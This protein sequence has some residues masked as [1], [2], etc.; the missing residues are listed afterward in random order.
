MRRLLLCVLI[1][2]AAL[3]GA[4]GCGGDDNSASPATTTEGST[5]AATTGETSDE[6]IV[7]G[8]AVS[9]T[10]F[11]TQI[12][13][14][15]LNGAKLAIE[16]VNERG[17]VLGRPLELITADTK[18]DVATV[19]VAAL[20]VIENGADIVL[21]TCDYDFGGPA[22]RVANEK[23]LL[24]IGCSGSHLY[25]VKGIGPLAFNTHSANATEAAT[26]AEFAYK[27]G[28]RKPYYLIDPSLEYTK[29]LC[30]D[31]E[32]V[33]DDFAGAKSAVGTD[34]FQPS[35]PSIAPQITRFKS[36]G[37]DADVI[38]LCSVQPAEGSAIRQIRAAGIDTPIVSG[39][40][41]EG[42]FWLDA[43]P[44]VNDVYHDAVGSLSGDDPR[45]EVNEF[46]EKYEAAY[47]PAPT[48]YPLF[49]YATIE[50]IVKA[51][52]E[53]GSTDG[54]ALAEALNS[55]E[56]EEV[57]LG[58]T[59]YTA[60]CHIPLGRGFPIMHWQNGK[61]VFVEFINPTRVPDAPC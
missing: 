34:T 26:I 58:P 36:R 4:V 19:S 11:L 45:P 3:F 21:T 56:E 61:N 49:G 44:N 48:S 41:A 40:G 28:W 18:T 14:P 15:I 57:I 20:E 35:D 24:A 46:F 27:K 59:T 53:A 9:L 51:I 17:G 16:D 60:D 50:T 39:Q 47:G 13:V 38:V 6:P 22:A 12:D 37:A 8:A 31:F 2:S 54:E 5:G 52:E 32:K 7:I 33:F 42:T 10:G 55:W 25:G 30:A 43:V 29:G 1:A 23:G